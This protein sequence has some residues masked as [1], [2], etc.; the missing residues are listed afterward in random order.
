[1]MTGKK[2]ISLDAPGSLRAIRILAAIRAAGDPDELGAL[3]ERVCRCMTRSGL[4]LH[5]I[6]H[7]VAKAEVHHVRIRYWGTMP[8]DRCEGVFSL[9]GIVE[10][11]PYIVDGHLAVT[12]AVLALVPRLRLAL[13]ASGRLYELLEPIDALANDLVPDRADAVSVE[14]VVDAGGRLLH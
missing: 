1:M 3:A 6:E 9:V 10:G 12:S 11:H 2:R 5:E 8:D 4:R 13:T 14:R 7:E